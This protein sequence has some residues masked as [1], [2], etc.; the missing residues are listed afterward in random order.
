MAAWLIPAL[1]T[2]GPHI[3]TILSVAMPVFSNKA[4]D[5]D[6]GQGANQGSNLGTEQAVLLQQQI[7]ELQTAASLNAENIKELAA[8]LQKAVNAI[9]QAAE[10]AQSRLQRMVALSMVAA[11]LAVVAVLV[12][13]GVVFTR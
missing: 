7:R 6:A 13:L 9:D 2:I 5:K 8:Q 10:V 1:K 4:V 11:A 12:A 3:G